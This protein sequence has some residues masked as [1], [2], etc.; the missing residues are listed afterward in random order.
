M[1]ASARHI[2]DL[3]NCTRLHSFQI[4]EEVCKKQQLLAQ[5]YD[6]KYVKLLVILTID[7][8]ILSGFRLVFFRYH[9]RLL[10][11]SSTIQLCGIANNAQL[12]RVPATKVRVESPVTI[13]VQLES[14]VRLSD[15]FL[16]SSTL[17][18]IRLVI[19]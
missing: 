10:D 11:I 14:G 8:A 4:L 18:Y 6:V 9:N 3:Q 17:T 5:D 12:E 2:H 7:Y 13:F 19:V 16:P 15:S 1:H